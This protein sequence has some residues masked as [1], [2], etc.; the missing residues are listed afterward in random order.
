MIRM[1]FPEVFAFI[2]HAKKK[3]VRRDKFDMSPS[4][5]CLTYSLK[6]KDVEVSDTGDTISI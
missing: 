3:E 5:A 6:M 1:V 2:W 4:E